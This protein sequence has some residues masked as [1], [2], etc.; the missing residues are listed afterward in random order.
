MLTKAASISIHLPRLPAHRP[1]AKIRAAYDIDVLEFC[2]QLQELRSRVDFDVSARGWCYIL[3]EYGL[4]KNDFDS[5]ERLIN[6]CRKNGNLP[7]DICGKD[8]KRAFANLEKIDDEDVEEFAQGWVD[9]LSSAHEQYTPAS[10]WE[11]QKHYVQMLVEKTD[12]KSLFLS[13]CAEF[14]V[15]IANIGGWADLDRR[16]E[17]ME[18]FKYWGAKGKQCVLLYCGDHDPGG[19]NI[20]NFLK[21]NLE[22]MVSAVG[23]TPERLVIDRFGLNYDFI[24]KHRLTW[25]N[26]LHTA[27]SKYPLNDKRHNDHDKP[28]VQNYLKQFKARKVEANALVVRPEAG[29]QL[30]RTA[31]VKYIPTTSPKKYQHKLHIVREE[32]RKAIVRCMRE[33]WDGR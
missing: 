6:D 31:I 7:I 21:S 33:E 1:S 16:A 13:V 4:H 11:N 10:F 5:A 23:W 3:E 14:H 30:C 25:I 22:D 17:M 18:R 8:E 20:S 32:A 27:N 26:N 15:P 24:Q 9:Y 19:L 29:R 12:L 2:K 28:Y